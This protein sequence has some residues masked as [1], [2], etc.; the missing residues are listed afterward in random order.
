VES[1]AESRAPLWIGGAFVAAG[2]IGLLVFAFSGKSGPQPVAPEEPVAKREEPRLPPLEKKPVLETVKPAPAP[3]PRIDVPVKPE[4]EPEPKPEIRPEPKPEVKAP[5]PPPPPPEAEVAKTPPLPP[6]EPA[7]KPEPAKDK[8]APAPKKEPPTVDQKKVD[9]AIKRG[10]AWLVSQAGN[11]PKANEG[12]PVKTCGHDGLV[13]W[14]LIHA[15]VSESQPVFRH[16]FKTVTE[17]EMSRTY[18]VALQ[19]MILEELERV[20]YQ[21]RILQCA[22]FLA[23][24][25][26]PSGQWYYGQPQPASAGVPTTAGPLPVP[27]GGKK[28]SGGVRQKPTVVRRLT[29]TPR[30]TG[31]TEGDNS[32]AQYAALGIRSCVDAGIDFPEDTYLRAR[33]WWR[34][35][36]HP[37]AAGNPGVATGAG[38]AAPPAGW[39][40]EAMDHM[41]GHPAY[42]SMTA[43]AVGALAIYDTILGADWRKDAGVE[44]GLSWLAKNF[45]VAGNPGPCSEPWA[46]GSPRYGHYYYLYALERAGVLCRTE[47]AG[48]HPWYFDGATFLLSAQEKDGAWEANVSSTCFAILFLKRA[49]RPLEDVA[50]TDER[51]K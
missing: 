12:Q 33:K 14:T 43:G 24:T 4:P 28:S 26:C 20:R 31:P 35:A 1:K 21:D 40:Y 3:E 10:V 15:G 49:T 27:T 51:R 41:G 6:V 46:N 18:E 36:Q 9:L 44:S 42:G 37:A 5:P 17:A 13:L 7:P 45:G 2:L 48:T 22:Q 8:P 38:L 23:D 30:K 19:A 39:C 34:G 47:W 29:V 11:L 16:L 25:Q 32:N 50:S